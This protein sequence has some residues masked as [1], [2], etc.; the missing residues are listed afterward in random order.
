MDGAHDVVDR[1]AL[2]VDV[3]H[4][5]HCLVDA[6]SLGQSKDGLDLVD[7]RSVADVQD[8]LV[9]DDL[10]LTREVAGLD[11]VDRLPHVPVCDEEQRLE[12]LLGDLDLLALDDPL[13]VE[14]DLAVAQLAEAEDDAAALDGLDDLGGG[15]A[16]E[17]EARGLAEV[18]D[19][20]PQGVLRALGQAVRLVQHDDLGLARRQRH[21]LLRE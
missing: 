16:A 11:V 6:S 20:H 9:S 7:A 17:H 13:E 1:V 18:A 8:Q 10:A 5:A 12:G 4:L 3:V 21:L 2:L 14:L 19:Y 15:V